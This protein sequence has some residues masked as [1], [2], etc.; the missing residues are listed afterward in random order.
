[1]NSF[2]YARPGLAD[3]LVKELTGGNLFSDAPN[4]LF[5]AEALRALNETSGK[6]LALN[7]DEAQ[8]SLTSTE[9]EIT[10]T[11]LNR[12]AISLIGPAQRIFCS[13]CTGLTGISCYD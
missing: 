4:G 2:Y 5:L 7:I 1:M 12:P 11:A 8:H 13:S 9:G 3:A 10:M 6:P